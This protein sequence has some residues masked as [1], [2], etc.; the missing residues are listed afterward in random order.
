MDEIQRLQIRAALSQLR[1]TL[2]KTLELVRYIV[3]KIADLY[4]RTDRAEYASEGFPYGDHEDGYS[5][6]LRFGCQRN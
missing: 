1:D 3:R 5:M 6:W 4:D 2:E